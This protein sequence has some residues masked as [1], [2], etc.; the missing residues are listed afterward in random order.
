M[1]EKPKP[2]QPVFNPVDIHPDFVVAVSRLYNVPAFQ[3]LMRAVKERTPQYP[4]TSDLQ[5]V[6]AQQ[7]M[8]RQG[9]EQAISEILN[10]G[11]K[12]ASPEEENMKALL[13]TDD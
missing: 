4:F 11:L 9:Y 8:L 7:S 13:D 10:I 3:E 6:V 5:H 1:S 2:E 12:S